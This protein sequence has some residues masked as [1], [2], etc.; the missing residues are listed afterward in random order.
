MDYCCTMTIKTEGLLIA[1][2]GDMGKNLN[3]P[4][5]RSV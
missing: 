4:V 1:E 3:L 2:I 5:I